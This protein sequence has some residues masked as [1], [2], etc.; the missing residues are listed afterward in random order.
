MQVAAG[1]ASVVFRRAGRSEAAGAPAKV[2]K[3]LG[4]KK[5]CNRSQ[6]VGT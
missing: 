6:K 1:E 3:S 5:H 2:E 4:G